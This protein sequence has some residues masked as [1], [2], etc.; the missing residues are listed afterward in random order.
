MVLEYPDR[1]SWRLLSEGMTYYQKEDFQYKEVPW[2][3]PT[4]VMQITFPGEYRLKT[5]LGDP[6]ASG[7]QSF[8]YLDI[9]GELPKGRYMTITPCFRDEKEDQFHKIQFMKLELYI[10]DMVT[11]ANLNDTIEICKKFFS[12]FVWKWPVEKVKMPDGSFD[13]V[14]NG[15]ELGSYG[16]REHNG[17]EWIYATGIAEPRLSQIRV[18]S[19][20]AK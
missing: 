14:C 6:V 13:L 1:I 12:K 17:L 11:R 7:E 19:I 20:R 3:V 16:I 10:T 18:M 5:P 4:D 9:N 2:L 15:I 8:L